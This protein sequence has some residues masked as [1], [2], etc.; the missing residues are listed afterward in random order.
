MTIQ[1]TPPGEVPQPDA[2]YLA[3]T[4]FIDSDHPAVREFAE[5]S[6][7]GESTAIGRAVKL[8]YAVR[9]GWRYDP[10]NITLRPETYTASKVLQGG[11][12]FCI[13]KAILLAAAA[14]AVGIPTGIG[15][16]DVVNHLTTE[17]LRER[18]GG[19]TLFL[20]HGYAVMYL[21]GRW[22]KAAPAFNIE[23]CQRFDVLPTDFDGTA[24]AVFQQFDAR[25]RR[26]MEYVKDHGTWSDFPFQ[27][28][29]DDFRDFYPPQTWSG[30]AASEK[31]EDGKAVR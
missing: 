15:L 28:V 12:C 25:Q 27:R 18:M 16:S 1:Y 21:E 29:V 4:A 22:V 26:H 13:P 3:S 7:A 17:K 11:P 30:Q 6:V 8:Y 10:F 24:D 31:F 14:R 23:L 19:K 20:H 5:R 2:A 9:D